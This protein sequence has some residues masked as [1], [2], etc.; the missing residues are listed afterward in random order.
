MAKFG[1]WIGGALGWAVGGPIGAVLGFAFGSMFDDT[2]LGQESFEGRAID[3]RYLKYRHQ[4][5]PGDFASALLVLSAVMMKADGKILKSELDYVRTFFEKNFGEDVAQ[6]HIKLLK[7][8]LDQDIDVKAVC[9][10]VKY[11]MQHSNRLFL[12]Q[13]LF[14]IAGADGNV[15]PE[16]VDTLRRIAGYLGIRQQDIDS[17]M[18]MHHKSKASHYKVLEIE[19]SVGDT[20]VKK[21]YRKMA[22]KYHPDKVS[23]LGEEYQKQ[24]QERF[25]KVQDAYEAIKKER[26]FK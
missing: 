6:H 8:V 18:G 9:D 20:E 1:K 11:F 15:A 25:V 2:S 4:T 3:D 21:A 17:V 12:L 23:N 5:R 7:G 16:E 10:Q 26:G 19:E 13:Y 22:N 14:G 24:A